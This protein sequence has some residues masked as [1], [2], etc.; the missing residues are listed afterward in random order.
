[1]LGF[2]TIPVTALTLLV[3]AA[4]YIAVLATDDLPSVPSSKKQARIGLDLDDA[5]AD[6]HQVSGLLSSKHIYPIFDC[7]S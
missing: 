6:L 3:Y 7:L 4:I 1:M 2:K 5:Y